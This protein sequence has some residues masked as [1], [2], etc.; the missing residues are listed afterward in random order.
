MLI[1]IARA[2][3]NRYVRSVDTGQGLYILVLQI[4]LSF[5][6]SFPRVRP[7]KTYPRFQLCLTRQFHISSYRP[8]PGISWFACER[9]QLHDK[10]ILHKIL[11]D[12]TL[13]HQ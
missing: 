2:S 11:L 12:K 7:S 6:G 1:I 4:H 10:V 9:E 3:L 8:K 13:L 5:L